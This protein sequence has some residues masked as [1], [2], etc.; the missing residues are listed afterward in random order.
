MNINFKISFT[1]WLVAVGAE[2][3]EIAMQNQRQMRVLE[4]IY[5]Q[6]CPS[7]SSE[8]QDSFCDDSQTLISSLTA[9]EDEDPSEQLET[10]SSFGQFQRTSAQNIQQ[11]DIPAHTSDTEHSLGDALQSALT[12]A[13]GDTAAA[14]ILGSTEPDVVAAASAAF[15]A[16]MKSNEHGSMIC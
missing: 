13:Q 12:T 14:R 5:P 6:H 16:I 8:M 2:S 7:V 3:E 15:T 11:Y 4:A 10:G 1:K 9:V